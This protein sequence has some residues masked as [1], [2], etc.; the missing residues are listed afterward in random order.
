MSRLPSFLVSA[1]PSVGIE[2]ASDRVTAVAIGQ[3]GGSHTVAG[4][5]VERLM[6]GVVT[7]S[8]NSINIHDPEAAAA[9]VRSALEKVGTRVRRVALAIP[10]TR[11]QA[12]AVST[13]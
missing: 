9:A 5:A 8:L 2:I 7:P 10:D 12:S 11:R 1:P 6:P 13:P 4:Y 3:Q